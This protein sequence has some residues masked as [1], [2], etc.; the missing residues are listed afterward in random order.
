MD[1]PLLL[2]T[3]PAHRASRSLLVISESPKGTAVVLAFL[4]S[5]PKGI[6]FCRCPC[7]STSSPKGICCLSFLSGQENKVQK[8]KIFSSQKTPSSTPQF[9][10]HSPQTHQQTSTFCTPLSP[11]TP[12]KTPLHQ[13]A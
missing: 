1:L 11:K 8:R 6:C 10:S 7:F 13:L 2:S 4:L 9:T 12:S 3:I 5:S